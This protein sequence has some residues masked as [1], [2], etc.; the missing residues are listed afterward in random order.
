MKITALIFLIMCLGM[1]KKHRENYQTIDLALLGIN[2]V[3]T[4]NAESS[5]DIVFGDINGNLSIFNTSVNHIFE[6][7][8]AHNSPIA[9]I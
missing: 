7:Q 2:N 5:R 8:Q 3:T 6:V 1:A 4:F 9:K